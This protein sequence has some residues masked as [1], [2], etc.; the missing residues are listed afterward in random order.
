[1]LIREWDKQ[2]QGPPTTTQLQAE[3]VIC[4]IH[5]HA[6]LAA[7]PSPDGGT[8]GPTLASRRGGDEGYRTSDASLLLGVGGLGGWLTLSSWSPCPRCLSITLPLDHRY[9]RFFRPASEQPNSKVPFARWLLLPRRPLSLLF[10][11]SVRRVHL[12][13]HLASLYSRLI[14]PAQPPNPSC[15][16]PAPA[17]IAAISI[18]GTPSYFFTSGS[19]AKRAREVVPDAKL[20]VAMC[21][22]FDIILDHFSRI[23][24]A[25]HELRIRIH[26]RRV[27]RPAFYPVPIGADG[28]CRSTPSP[29]PLQVPFA[30]PC[31]THPHPEQF[32]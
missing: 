31:M 4:C 2:G 20:V 14:F 15:V 16:P 29:S 7:R 24:H 21:G 23:S 28:A 10:S 8:P 30:D 18:E 19:V 3:Y 6:V 17:G 25:T 5:P 26:A 32:H 12:I 9:A 1:M 13:S 22:N 11:V 27:I